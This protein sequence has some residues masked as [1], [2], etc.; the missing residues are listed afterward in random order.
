MTFQGQHASRYLIHLL[1]VLTK[2]LGR[3]PGV[4]LERT[5]RI[6]LQ[7]PEDQRVYVQ[8]DGEFA[9]RLPARIEI[10]E[11]ALTLLVPADVRQRLGVRVTEALPAAG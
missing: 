10:V 4:H 1:G 6:E 9:G 8:V 3:F 5:C 11:S 7:N 2:S